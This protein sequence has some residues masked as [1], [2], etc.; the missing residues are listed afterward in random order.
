MV[1]TKE[2]RKEVIVKHH[3]PPTSGHLGITKTGARITNYV[4][5]FVHSCVICL[6]K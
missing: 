6:E 5:K 3:D 1:K 2:K 4:A